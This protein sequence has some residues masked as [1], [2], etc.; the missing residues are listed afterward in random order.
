MK[1]P[2][3]TTIIL[4]TRRIRKDGTYPVKLRLTYRRKQK[5]YRIGFYLRPEEF[6]KVY[7][8]RS[9]GEYK[10]LQMVFNEI[11]AEAR[12][13]I[14]KMDPFSFDGF[15]R[16]FLKR[17]GD[18][19]DLFFAFDKQISLLKE[20]GR[21][22]SAFDYEGAKKSLK[23]YWKKEKLLF[24]DVT[25]AFLRKFEQHLLEK[26]AS[27]TTV[28]MRTRCIR[29]LF[30]LAIKEK[31]ID[32]ELYPFGDPEAGYYRPPQHKNIK[33]ALSKEDI[34]KIYEYRPLEG[35]PEHF[36]RD[37]WL[38][39]Y[40][41]NGINIADICRLKYKHLDGDSIIFIRHKT[42][43]NRIIKPVV[44][45]LIQPIKEIIERWGNK[46][47]LK[48]NFVF[49]LLSEEMDEEAVVRK[50]KST[51]RMLNTHINR[52]A[53]KV[54][55]EQKV[56]SYSARHSFATVLKLS[57]ENIAY[58]SEAL[59]HTNLKTTENYLASFDDETR[60]AAAKKLLDF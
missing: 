59:G 4:D 13:V 56:T 24:E 10:K 22:N 32:P 5:L 37:L 58:I 55:I 3:L 6:E 7:S 8:R 40:L 20:M 54:G 15:T 57:G 33:K 12:R 48:E 38:F 29:R 28:S 14:E 34:K 11:E 16:R 35:T 44:V 51:T 53:G 50:I 52:I 46:P 9:H 36:Y 21:I 19:N 39:S 1:D 45:P 41:C 25:P 23:K 26:G 49:P 42:A 31:D 18:A 2:V 27:P 30:N 60:R 47:A 43:H 17:S